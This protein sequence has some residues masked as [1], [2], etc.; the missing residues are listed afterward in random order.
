MEKGHS[1]KGG[2]NTTTQKSGLVNLTPPPP[3]TAIHVI[4]FSTSKQV[5]DKFRI[6]L[7]IRKNKIFFN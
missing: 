1:V 2:D 5:K 3:K 7:S 4:P 6:N